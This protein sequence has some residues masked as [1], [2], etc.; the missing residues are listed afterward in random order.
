MPAVI[1]YAMIMHARKLVFRMLVSV[2]VH[3]SFVQQSGVDRDQIPQVDHKR[4]AP[5][6]ALCD[7][8]FFSRYMLK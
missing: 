2:S 8:S 5:Y 7:A 1:V 6:E 3:S 4:L